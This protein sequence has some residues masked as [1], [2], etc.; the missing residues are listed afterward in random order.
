VNKKEYPAIVRSHWVILPRELHRA[1]AGPNGLIFIETQI[2]D[3]RE[4]DFVGFEADYGRLDSSEVS[5][6]TWTADWTP[7][8]DAF[9]FG[10][11]GFFGSHMVSR[12]RAAGYWVRGVDLLYP[13]FSGTAAF[14]FVCLD[15]TA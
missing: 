1:T 14:E 6:F 3:C 5:V 8:P 2:G 11:G 15:L 4:E 13:E 9:V 10:A 7:L 12:L